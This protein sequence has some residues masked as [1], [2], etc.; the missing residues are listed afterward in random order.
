MNIDLLFSNFSLLNSSE[1]IQKLKQGILQLAVR[2]GLAPQDP[3]DEPAYELIKKIKAEKD[4]LSKER[5]IKQE[6]PGPPIDEDEILYKL[7]YGWEWLRL[8]DI[9]KISS[10]DNL[11]SSQ[12][13]KIGN[14]PVYGGNGITGYHNQFNV[15]ERTI[16][17]GRVG[18]YCGS[19]HLTEDKA[20][21]T[22]NA[23]ITKYSKQ[24][25]DRDFLAILLKGTNLKENENATAQPVISGRKIYPIVIGLPPLNEQMRIVEKVD[26]LFSR[27]DEIEPKLKQADEEIVHLNKSA[28]NQL[29]ESKDVE[30]FKKKFEFI[31][32]NFDLLYSDERNVKEL[33]Q[34][35]LQLAV[36]GKLVPQDRNDEPANELIKKIKAEKE[37]LIKEGKLKKE[38]PLPPISKT[39]I[40]YELPNGWAWVRLVGISCKIHYGFTASADSTIKEIKLLRITDIQN[41][42]VNWKK[43]PG[44]EIEENELTKFLL[45]K[46]D[47]LIARTGGTIGKSYLVQELSVKAVFASYLIRIIPS[48]F[49]IS[50]FIKIFLD[51][52]LYWNQLISKSMGTGQPNVNG[53]S[54]SQLLLPLPS[55]NEQKRIV[56]Q[57]YKLMNLCDELESKI[58]K[59]KEG[60]EILIGAILQDVFKQ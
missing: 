15:K 24:N 14:I 46:N 21:I 28:L 27:A 6:K 11:T 26:E 5:K 3:N 7:P 57:V 34:A 19:I 48:L 41:N 23:F 54:L 37:K 25:I 53:V 4:K 43:V 35:I 39:E 20:W 55:Q 31:F 32:E 2:G 51:S 1:K 10:G 56:L 58:V 47:L 17:I 9:I 22:D 60:S 38:K 50:E 45:N 52:P 33:R 59:S 49:V 36:Q 8:G 16:V 13:A 29:L 44:C 30:E 42:K 12:M 40:P 18:Y